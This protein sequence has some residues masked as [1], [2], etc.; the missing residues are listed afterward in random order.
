M[1]WVKH[2]L[3]FDF[4]LSIVSFD[5]C[6]DCVRQRSQPISGRCCVGV[7]CFPSLFLLLLTQKTLKKID[8]N[9]SKERFLLFPERRFFG[10]HCWSATFYAPQSSVPNFCENCVLSQYSS[11]HIEGRIDVWQFSVVHLATNNNTYCL[12]SLLFKRSWC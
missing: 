6:Q 10:E 7:S 11:S 12:L 9:L 5:K 1:F 2:V 8:R 3:K 4:Q